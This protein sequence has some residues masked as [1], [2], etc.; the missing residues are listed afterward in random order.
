M[1]GAG[2]A[3][4]DAGSQ[5][6]LNPRGVAVVRAELQRAGH[7]QHGA[8]NVFHEAGPLPQE[9]QL[10]VKNEPSSLRMA[11]RHAPPGSEQL[12]FYEA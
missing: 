11:A 12:V 8:R 2:R 4:G 10:T 7:S 3:E 5:G 1:S 9:T 6:N